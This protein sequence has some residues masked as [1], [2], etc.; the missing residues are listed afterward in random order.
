MRSLRTRTRPANKKINNLHALQPDA[1]GSPASLVRHLAF[2]PGDG[3][4][5]ADLLAIPDHIHC[6]HR[7]RHFRGAVSRVLPDSV[8]AATDSPSVFDLRLSNSMRGHCRAVGFG[9]FW[10]VDT[11]RGL[12][13]ASRL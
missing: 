1:F 12:P 11:D 8:V 5:L 13:T 6:D 7:C 2:R 10:S 9:V 3:A 4:G